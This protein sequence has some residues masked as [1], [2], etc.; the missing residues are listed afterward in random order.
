MGSIYEPVFRTKMDDLFDL[1]CSYSLNRPRHT[2]TIYNNQFTHK[3]ESEF[4]F[5]VTY[6]PLTQMPMMIVIQTVNGAPIEEF[7]VDGYIISYR[8]QDRSSITYLPQIWADL[9][10]KQDEAIS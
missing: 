6:N 9:Y 10:K 7:D 4:V 1:D 3:E 2:V 8:A 5:L